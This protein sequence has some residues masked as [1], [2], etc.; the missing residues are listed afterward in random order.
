[1]SKNAQGGFSYSVPSSTMLSEGLKLV[2]SSALLGGQIFSGQVGR[3]CHEDAALE[4]DDVTIK[5]AGAPRVALARAPAYSQSRG[6]SVH[7]LT[8]S[9]GA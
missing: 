4:F 7:V 5:S 3:L 6:F 2:I 1:M 8:T 9:T